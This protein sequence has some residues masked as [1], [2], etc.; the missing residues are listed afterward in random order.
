MLSLGCLQHCAEPKPERASGK[1]IYDFLAH[2]Q[3]AQ[4]AHYHRERVNFAAEFT[5]NEEKR[6]LI[7][8]HPDAE[9]QFNNVAIPQNAVLQFGIGMNPQVWDKAGDGV[10]FEI[11]VVDEKSAKIQIF[12]SYID[13]KANSSDRKWVDHDVDLSDFSGQKVSFVFVTTAGP[14]GDPAYDWAGW[15][16]PKVRLK[17]GG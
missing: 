6:G 8:E 12:S 14:R 13:P 1:V 4:I 11:K 5:I 3:D 9:V 7:F 2:A 16:N 15:S 10:T 17:T